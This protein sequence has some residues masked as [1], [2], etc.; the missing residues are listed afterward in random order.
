MLHGPLGSVHRPVPPAGLW[1][2][3]GGV[4]SRAEGSKQKVI[5][6]M[7]AAADVMAAGLAQLRLHIS[8]KTKLVT[9]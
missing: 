9:S 5:A 4:A 2:Y 7:E 3:I 8:S 6:D 1:S